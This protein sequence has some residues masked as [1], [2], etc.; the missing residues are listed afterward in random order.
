[1]QCSERNGGRRAN[2]PA[3]TA[4][5]KRHPVLDGDNRPAPADLE[6]KLREAEDRFRGAFDSAA[7]GMALVAPDGRWQEVN[8]A[9]C[10]L[11]GYSEDELLGGTFQGITHPADL[12]ADLE[13]VRQ[14]LTAEIETYQ[15]DK[16]YF[17]KL[18]HVIWIH[19]NVSLIRAPDGAPS[20]FV[21]QIQDI[22]QQRRAEQLE[23]LLRALT[24]IPTDPRY[25][26]PEFAGTPAPRQ[27]A[28][29]LSPLTPRERQILG[30]VADGLTNV[31]AAQA[32]EVSPETIQSHI[33]NAMAKLNA[34]TRTQAVAT[35]FRRSLLA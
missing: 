12:D 10:D 13:F 3:G 31:K 33:R 28:G 25:V 17:H 26:D 15:M 30:L 20:Y 32:L 35:A 23:E 8:P 4:S 29:A 21:S 9:L 34:D 7:I 19:L 2:N 5:S 16:R 24:S 27:I 6:R 1:M 22:R 11:V 18:G 14:M